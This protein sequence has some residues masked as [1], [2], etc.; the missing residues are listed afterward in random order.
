MSGVQLPFL[1]GMDALEALAAPLAP[2]LVGR[3]GSQLYLTDT[4]GGLP[5]LLAMTA[6]SE[7]GP[8][9]SVYF[10]ALGSD[11]SQLLSGRLKGCRSGLR[12]FRRR[13]V[14]ANAEYDHM[15]GWRTSSIRREGE[16]RKLPKRAMAAQYKHVYRVEETDGVPLPASQPAVRP[17]EA[18]EGEGTAEAGR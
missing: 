15:V 4:E 6:D 13:V 10:L 7:S 8:F 12:A 1:L 18:M 2:L 16:L 3:T 11:A 5:L 17:A 14:Y 9:L